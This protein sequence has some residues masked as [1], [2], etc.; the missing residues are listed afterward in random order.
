MIKQGAQGTGC[1]SGILKAKDPYA[2]VEEMLSSLRRAWD[3]L[4]Y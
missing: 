1:T 3:E 4:H 2:M